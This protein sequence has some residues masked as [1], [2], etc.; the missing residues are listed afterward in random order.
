ME[1]LKQSGRV[2]AMDVAK[3]MLDR[4]M[5]PPTMY[6]PLIVHEP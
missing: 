1:G 6:F 3:S 5:H 4:G 2:S